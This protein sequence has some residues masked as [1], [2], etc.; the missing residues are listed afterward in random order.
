[1]KRCYIFILI[2][3]I[4][5]TILAIPASGAGYLYR[6]AVLPFDDGSIKTRWWKEDFEL[7]SSITDEMITALAETK[8]FRIIERSQIDDILREHNL[9]RAGLL[10]PKTAAKVGRILGV[11]YLILGRVTEFSSKTDT[12]LLGNPN[13]DNP[14]GMVINNTIAR[15]ALDARMVDTTTAEILTTA[16]GSGERKNITLG[17]ATKYGL[18][19]F[20]A[21]DFEK[22]DMGKALRQAVNSV[23]Y[24]LATKVYDGHT[25]PSLTLHGKIAYAGPSQII[26]NLG[27]NE[28]VTQGMTFI[29]RHVIDEVKDPDTGAIVDDV[30]EPAAEIIVNSVKGKS[31]TCSILTNYGSKYRIAVKDQVVSKEPLQIAA[32][33]PLEPPATETVKQKNS[34]KLYVDTTYFTECQD[35]AF[36]SVGNHN[37]SILMWGGEFNINNYIIGGERG[38]SNDF[39]NGTGKVDIS[40]YKIGY[41]LNND[42]DYKIALYI[43][44]LELDWNHEAVTNSSWMFG[45]D[46]GYNIT[47]KMY[48]EMS[49]GYG[50]DPETK[51]ASGE[52][53]A[54]TNITTVKAKVDYSVAKNTDLYVGYRSYMIAQKD[55]QNLSGVMAGITLKF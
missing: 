26:I 40:E 20:G 55:D 6:V 16:T 37:G 12:D 52:E 50:I 2:L 14:M 53:S 17:T 23:A 5:C 10:D 32:L 47:D 9:S 43:S 42:S 35:P 28:G 39:E 54:A 11:Q 15:V 48:L 19:V 44:K 7:T 36:S 27:A 45:A 4:I 22:S 30:T 13:A 41:N 34:A 49:F 1:M 33:P 31:A 51:I 8:R 3:I 24:Q 46:V 18:M 21:K 38:M 29:V 25:I